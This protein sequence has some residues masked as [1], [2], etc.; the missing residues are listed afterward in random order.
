MKRFLLLLIAMTATAVLGAG[1]QVDQDE[2]IKQNELTRRGDLV[3]H[4][5]PGIIRGGENEISDIIASTMKPPEDDSGK[6]FITL[7]T[8]DGCSACERLKKDLEGD[9]Y[10]K[11]F[12]NTADAKASWAHYNAYNAKDQTQKW[13]L[14]TIKTS[15]YP[16]LVIQPPR[17][18]AYGDPKTIVAQK[19]GYD[20]NSRQLATWM[21][22]SIAA[23]AKKVQPR[24]PIRKSEK[25]SVAA[26]HSWGQQGVAPPFTP[27]PPNVTPGTPV[28]SPFSPTPN[29]YEFPPAGPQ[30]ATAAELRAT[31]PGASSDFIV[32]QLVSGATLQQAATAWQ[33]QQ[34]SKPQPSATPTSTDPAAKRAT[35]QELR[36]A[37]PDASGQLLWSFHRDGKTVQEAVDAYNAIVQTTTTTPQPSIG[38]FQTPVGVGA[39]LAG[40]LGAGLLAFRNW[41]ISQ[42]KTP[43]LTDDQFKVVTGILTT[44]TGLFAAKQTNSTTN[45]PA[46][47]GQ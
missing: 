11:A 26:T 5:N 37:L 17:S 24:Q 22:D 25:E 33:I 42:N 15:G 36:A 2:L 13:F 7:I 10:L 18:G 1:P 38:F 3:T 28:P 46:Q 30:P 44:L 9:R 32:Q 39:T 40:L 41:R 14:D 43:F 35:L 34:A 8:T 45:P 29:P 23:Y 12:V 31:F 21:R 16:T 27:A 4:I 6:W 20:G 47:P 19:V